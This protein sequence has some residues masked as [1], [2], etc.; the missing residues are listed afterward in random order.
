MSEEQ[1]TIGQLDSVSLPGDLAELWTRD[2]D[3]NPMDRRWSLL[4]ALAWLASK[5]GLGGPAVQIVDADDAEDGKI[6]WVDGDGTGDDEP[7][8]FPAGFNAGPGLL[9]AYQ[10]N[11]SNNVLHV[12]IGLIALSVIGLLAKAGDFA[13][14]RRRLAV[15][16]VSIYWHFVDGV[17][18]IIFSLVYLLGLVA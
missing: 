10:A 15:D 1:K 9:V 6:Y 5:T 2:P 7:Q 17:W 12:F 14:G 8:N 3:L 11:N 13:G 16:V 18:V 4:D